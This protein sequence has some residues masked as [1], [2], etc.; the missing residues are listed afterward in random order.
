MRFEGYS[1]G[2]PHKQKIG[3]Q[4]HLVQKCEIADECRQILGVNFFGGGEGAE[5]MEKQG[6]EVRGK[7]SLKK[8]AEKFA[9]NFLN[10]P[11]QN[12]QFTPNPLCR[13]SGSS[14]LGQLCRENQETLVER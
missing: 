9:A 6:R 10:S 5:A 1:F 2:L 8:F 12:K 3:V 11:D 7:I 14:S 4:K 13:A